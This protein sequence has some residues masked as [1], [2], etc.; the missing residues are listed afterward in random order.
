MAD[1]TFSRFQQ[2][3][4]VQRTKKEDKL[5]CSTSTLTENMREQPKATKLVYSPRRHTKAV[6]KSDENGKSS[7]SKSLVKDTKTKSD[8][9]SSSSLSLFEGREKRTSLKVLQPSAD[10]QKL[11]VGGTSGRKTKRDT[12]KPKKR[13]QQRNALSSTQKQLKHYL[14]KQSEEDE[15]K[16]SSSEVENA[17]T[18]V[19]VRPDVAS[20]SDE[21]LSLMV[22]DQAPEKYW[23]LLAEE[24][25]KALEETLEENMKLYE[26]I[27]NLKAENSALKE[28][29]SNTDY[30]AT[31]YKITKNDLPPTEDPTND[32]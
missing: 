3:V 12:Q 7:K 10:G 8:D 30:F 16:S 31:M 18:S 21:V 2:A 14:S 26:I 19:A 11:L 29:A 28:K 17:I 4:E 15:T 5:S 22:L 9:S 6:G 1:E 32:C 23:E 25:R 27:E 13:T 24:R 20:S